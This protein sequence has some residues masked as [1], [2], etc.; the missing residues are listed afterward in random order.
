MRLLGVFLVITVTA[1]F[2]GFAADTTNADPLSS[3]IKRCDAILVGKVNGSTSYLRKSDSAI[4]TSYSIEVTSVISGKFPT[5]LRIDQLGG[6]VG[7]TSMWPYH[8]SAD[9][10]NGKS[11]LLYLSQR[12]DGTLSIVDGPAGAIDSAKT[13]AFYMRNVTQRVKALSHVGAD[14]SDQ[15]A[16]NMTIV[17][18]IVSPNGLSTTPRRFVAQDQGAKIPVIVDVS[19]RPAGISIAQ[20]MTALENA[21]A[22]WEASTSIRFRITGTE[23][24]TTSASLINNSDRAIRVQ[25]HD[26]FNDISNTSSTIGIGGAY[27][28][29]TNGTGGIL[30]GISFRNS[31]NGYVVIE[32]TKSSNSGTANLEAVLTHEIGHV[33]GLAHS[34][35]TSPEPNTASAQAIMYFQ[36]HGD[37]R[38]AQLNSYDTTTARQAYPINSGVPASMT[39]RIIATTS[40][41]TITNAKVNQ[42][43]VYDLDGDNVTATISSQS[44]INGVFSVLGTTVTFTPNGPFGDNQV[45]NPTNSFFDQAIITVSDGTNSGTVDFRVIGFA[46]DSGTDGIPNAWMT[47][48]FN[49]STPTTGS[50]AADDPDNDGFT[51]LD[52]YLLGSDPNDGGSNLK[53]TQ[54]SIEASSTTSDLSLTWESSNYQYYQIQ[55]S[56][57]LNTWQPL[58]Y[59]FSQGATTATENIDQPLVDKRYYR[60]L[61]L[62]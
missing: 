4:M 30:N 38:G 2:S 57:N 33:I 8:I 34:S 1:I 20:A 54:H 60:V 49:S 56:T 61:R 24:F 16:A 19:T 44:N 12:E 21:L 37:G 27:F 5:T 28:S 23:T 36:A 32:H 6:T 7:D 10:V 40:F 46:F 35:E 15:S 51:N 62:Q 48:H 25:M 47:T 45:G 42:I 14:V 17:N 53:L 3:R 29:G 50:R 11:Y 18:K 39:R 55:S 41:G 22:A 9:L 31:T 52:E 43:Q 59:V 26:N 13:N 58:Q